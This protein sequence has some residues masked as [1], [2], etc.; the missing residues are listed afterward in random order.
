MENNIAGEYTEKWVKPWKKSQ[1]KYC[2]DSTGYE[3]NH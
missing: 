3:Q 2:I 1:Q